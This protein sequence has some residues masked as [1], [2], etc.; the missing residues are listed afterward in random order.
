MVK[1]KERGELFCGTNDEDMLVRCGEFINFL[2]DIMRNR[3][4]I[5]K[6]T[7]WSVIGQ[8][9]KDWGMPQ[10][11]TMIKKEGWALKAICSF[12]INKSRHLKTGG[13]TDVNVVQLCKAY[14]SYCAQNPLLQCLAKAK[15]APK[16]SPKAMKA[17]STA[18]AAS[19]KERIKKNSPG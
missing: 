5:S 12:I 3:P 10:D 1:A 19:P 2:T 4:Y 7:M 17:K 13:R 14:Q 16:K 8:W 9:F 18:A 15:A 11:S 6:T